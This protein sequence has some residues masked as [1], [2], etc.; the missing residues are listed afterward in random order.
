MSYLSRIAQTHASFELSREELAYYARHILLPGIGLAGQRKLKAARVLVVGAGGLG[1]PVLQALAGAGVGY[2]TVVD[3]DRISISNL[4]RQW[5]H[6]YADAGGNKAD[7]AASAL[8]SLNPFIEVAS[9][10]EM[11]TPGN[12]KSLIQ[13]H[14]LVIDATDDLDAR[15]WIDEACGALDCPWVHAALYRDRAQLTVFWASCGAGFRKLYPEPSEAPSCSGSGMIGA[16]A[17]IVG[18]LQALEAIKLI[19]GSSAPKIGDLVSLDTAGLNLQSFKIPEVTAPSTYVDRDKAPSARAVSVE[20]LW[21]ALSIHEAVQFFDLR[22]QSRFDEATIPDA[23]HFPAERMLEDGFAENVR[24]KVVLF[25]EE[26][27][28]S[29]I[30]AEALDHESKPIYYLEGGFQA[31][32]EFEAV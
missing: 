29:A 2:L 1:C 26:G 6:R 9:Q 8:R 3:G 19:T 13:S 10:P 21:Q 25:C 31:W 27:L 32:S 18:N 4:S 24:G 5:L 12:A 20:S 7:S 22:S 17:S 30:I 16:S 14:D 11:L 15:Y 28:M 23:V